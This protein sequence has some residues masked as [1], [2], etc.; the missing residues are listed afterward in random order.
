M[1]AFIDEHR[2]VFGVEPICRLLQI[3]PSTYYAHVTQR[4]DPTKASVRSRRDAELSAE[5]RR[6][7]QAN[8]EVYGAR[9]IWRQL[10]R[11]GIEV[12]RCTVERLMRS[13][14]IQG[15][16]RGKPAKT[17]VSD[18]AAPCPADRVNRQFQAPRPNLLWVSDFTYVSTWQGFVYAAFVIDAF[19]RRIVGWRVSRTATAGFVLDALEQALH[20]RRPVHRDGLIHHSDR[21]V[22]YV[23][24]KY[25]E[26]LAEAGLQP[27][28]GSVGDSYDNALAET[29][30]GLYKTEVIRR[31]GPWRNLDKVELATL[32]WVDWFNNRRLLEPIGNLPPA[33][34]EQR[35]YELPQETILAA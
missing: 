28:V 26:R 8:F 3:A 25:T 32:E 10:G 4:D 22:Q 12:A 20:E 24:I 9:K 18:K 21:G 27:S 7:F 1:I 29:V 15:V 2:S 6:V 13:L 23:S 31:R 5:I 30:I 33:E 11:E 14:G 35:F 34:A 17:T 19:A 16:V